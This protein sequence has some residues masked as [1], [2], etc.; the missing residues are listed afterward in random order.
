MV[1]SKIACDACKPLTQG[2]LQFCSSLTLIK[3]LIADLE[4]CLTAHVLLVEFGETQEY[5]PAGRVCS[6]AESLNV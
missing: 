6:L 5:S 4:P 3:G 2:V 1:G